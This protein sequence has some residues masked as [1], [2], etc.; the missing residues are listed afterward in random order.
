M[1]GSG[2]FTIM[3]RTELFSLALLTP[4]TRRRLS[5][6]NPSLPRSSPRINR[7]TLTLKALELIRTVIGTTKWTS[8]AE[9]LIILE[10]L[11]REFHASYSKDPCL[12]NIVRRVMNLVRG[13]VRH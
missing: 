10:G 6:P 13:E 11:G 3:E 1:S 4:V 8:G 9:L 2:N 7:N 12:S 5:P